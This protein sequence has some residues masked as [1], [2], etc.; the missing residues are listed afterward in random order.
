MWNKTYNI[1]LGLGVFLLLNVIVALSINDT[2]RSSHKHL[3]EYRNKIHKAKVVL[4]GNSVLNSS[5]DEKT[6][7]SLLGLW[8]T[9][10][11]QG[12]SASAS[13]Y[14]TFKNVV[15]A[16]PKRPKIVVFFF[17]D[18]FWTQPFYRTT[19]RYRRFIDDQSTNSEPLLDRLIFT[20]DPLQRFIQSSLPSFGK[21]E[22]LQ[23][24]INR[25][26]KTI[27]SNL[28]KMRIQSV[29]KAAERAFHY[30]KMQKSLVEKEQKK[31]ESVAYQFNEPFAEAI[32]KSFLP[33]VIDLAESANIQ[34]VFVRVKK[35]R[36]LVSNKQTTQLVQYIEDMKMYLSLRNIPLIDFTDNRN[37]TEK[38]FGSGDH[39]NSKK[40]KPL[41]TR[42]LAKQLKS[43]LRSSYRVP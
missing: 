12:G 37:I 27:V 3:K 25:N 11:A 15:I 13:W 22:L 24:I 34:L 14:L 43:V 9:K 36:D 39:L 31:A 19:G 18:T 26:L 5:V 6:L 4:I 30:S 38:H 28:L 1:L 21:R 29:D 33:H 10:L 2:N 41:F 16:A 35:R 17:R 8:C 7:S 32:E 20:P 23:D 42:L 40:G